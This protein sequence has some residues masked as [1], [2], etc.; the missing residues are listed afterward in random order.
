LCDGKA[1]PGRQFR[2][3]KLHDQFAVTQMI[4]FPVEN[5][6]YA[7]PRARAHMRFVYFDGSRNGH[8]TIPATGE[9]EK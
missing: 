2:S 3:I 5:F 4:A 1:P 9:Q 6:L 8:F 7:S